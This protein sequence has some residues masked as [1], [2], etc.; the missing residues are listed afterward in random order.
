MQ[1]SA[2]PPIY[3]TVFF[4]SRAEQTLTETVHESSGGGRAPWRWHWV[5]L[6]Q[7]AALNHQPLAVPTGP[8]LHDVVADDVVFLCVPGSL[9][10]GNRPPERSQRSA[11]G[12]GL[13]VA[14]VDICWHHQH[15]KDSPGTM[16]AFDCRIRILGIASSLVHNNHSGRRRPFSVHRLRN[17]NRHVETPS[18]QQTSKKL[19]EA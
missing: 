4:L 12:R 8:S 13:F 2:C 14:F 9:A 5:A 10:C 1:P 17:A 11:D 19:G 16:A 3:H 6:W 15:T 18:W 7:A